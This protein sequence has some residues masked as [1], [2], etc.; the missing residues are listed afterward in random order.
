MD[1]T[2]ISVQILAF[3]LTCNVQHRA[4]RITRL[5]QRTNRITRT[6]TSAGNRHTQT[7]K[8]G[9]GIGH[10]HTARFATCTHKAGFFSAANGIG[11]RQIVY[12]DDAV[13]AVYLMGFQY[14]GNGLAH[15]Y[16]F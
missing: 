14:S 13:H 3:Y 15:I 10:G 12:G 4:G 2:G 6:R 8:T 9:M 11:N 16:F 7:F 5:N 1:E